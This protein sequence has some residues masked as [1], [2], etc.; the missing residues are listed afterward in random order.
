MLFWVITLTDIV[1]PGTILVAEKCVSTPVG[2]V[3]LK[4][5]PW[6][7]SILA[8]CEDI[9]IVSTLPC[10]EP[11]IICE[12]LKSFPPIDRDWETSLV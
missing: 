2:N 4:K 3:T 6:L 9:V 10:T 1:C 8:V 12:P 11:V 5:L 7:Q